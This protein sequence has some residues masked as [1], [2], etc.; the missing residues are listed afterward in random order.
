MSYDTID[1]SHPNVEGMK[2][3]AAMVIKASEARMPRTKNRNHF[4][5]PRQ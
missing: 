4:V 3:L 1:G 5:C 2:A